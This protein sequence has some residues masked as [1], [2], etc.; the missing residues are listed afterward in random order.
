MQFSAS[1]RLAVG[2]LA[3][4]SL[5]ALP[6]V[7]GATTTG[8]FRLPAGD[9]FVLNQPMLSG[10]DDLTYGYRI[11]TQPPV[12]VNEK[13]SGCTSEFFSDTTVGPFTHGVSF[14][15]FLE[16]FYTAPPYVFYS[17]NLKHTTISGTHGDWF[18]QTGDGDFGMAPP[19][20]KYHNPNF[21]VKLEYTAPGAG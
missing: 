10:C 12:T 15:L 8:T 5:G 17:T 19:K 18:I 13:P 20:V 21:T 14:R 4:A 1:H 11:G 6:A 2:C 16:D 9:S 7:A 3:A